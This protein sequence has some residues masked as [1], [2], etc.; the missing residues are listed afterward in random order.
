MYHMYYNNGIIG[1]AMSILHFAFPI[2][3]ILILF[4][5]FSSKNESCGH[6]SDNRSD[7]TPLNML[8]ERYAKGEI[9]KEEFQR[10]KDDLND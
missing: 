4:K 7:K 10:M 2:I 1:W 8:K 3:F 9:S 5:L 6:Y